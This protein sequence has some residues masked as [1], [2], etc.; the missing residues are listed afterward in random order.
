M[1]DT[2][3]IPF[4]KA[5]LQGLVL[6]EH[7][8]RYHYDTK[9]AGLAVCVTAA[10]TRTFYF[11]KK[12]DGRPV[13]VRIG[14][15]PDLSVENARNAAKQLTLAVARGEDPQA[16]KRARRTETTL[17]ELWD[18]WMTSHAGPHK[19]SAST[20][21]QR[22]NAYLSQWSNRR[23]SCIKQ[24]D[25]R[26]LHLQMRATPYV[27]NRMVALLR[28]MYNVAPE[29]GYKGDNPARG[30]KKYREASRDRFL[31]PDELPPFFQA[32]DSEPNPIMRTFFLVALLTGARRS[33]VCAMQWSQIDLPTATWRIPDTK[34]GEP[35][36]VPLLPAA[37]D[38][39]L[40][41]REQS[42]DGWV[43]PARNRRGHAC[44]HLS[45]PMPAWRRLLKRAGLKGL[46]IHD[47]RRTAG[48]YMAITG[49]TLQIIGKALG[50]TQQQTTAIY[51]R[52]T[53]ESVRVAMGRGADAM[54]EAAGGVKLL[55]AHSTPVENGGSNEANG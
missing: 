31:M 22:W 18:Y 38:A 11:V 33:N 14:T 44:P 35:Q 46:R 5:A 27:A 23:L 13:R 47:L 21:R 6:P 3:K 55:E 9:A 30:I 7:G 40:A 52:L 43:F 24:A 2:V 50:H 15:F 42:V 8:R 53:N 41:I 10:G 45:D 1:P 54:N 37:L 16:D 4:T 49:T 19:K 32:L 29:I 39:L 26:T 12:I 17:G 51:S 48:S 34:R 20:D 28:A 36:V 25:V